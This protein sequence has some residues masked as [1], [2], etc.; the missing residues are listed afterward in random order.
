MNLREFARAV[1]NRW[2]IASMCVVAGIVVGCTFYIVRPPQYT[3]T[4]Q[5]YVSSQGDA[6]AQSAYQGAQL[7]QQRV[8]SYVELISSVRTAEEVSRSIQGQDPAELASK[9][10]ATSV[11]D[12]VLISVS[13][14][15]E[16]SEG[17][18]TLVNAVG[19][20]FPRIVSEVERTADGRS[21]VQVRPV[22]SADPPIDPSSAG[23][24]TTLLLGFVL[25]VCA[26]VA[27][28]LIRERTDRTIRTLASLREHARAPALGDV[29]SDRAV[30][31]SSTGYVALAPDSRRAEAVRKVR[32]NLTFVSVDKPPRVLCVTSPHAGDGKTTCTI[33]LAIAISWANRSVIVVDADL[34]R[35]TLAPRLALEPRVGLSQLL[36][37]RLDLNAAVQQTGI[38][39]AS[40][41]ASG[42]IP[43]NPSELLGSER[44]SDLLGEL[45]KRYDYVL[46]D[47]PPINEVVDAAV[48]GGLADGVILCAK[49]GKSTIDSVESAAQ[50]MRATGCHVVGSI[51]TMSQVESQQSYSSYGAYAARSTTATGS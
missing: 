21:L 1:R 51:L 13:A 33:D 37:G 40:A 7:S 31:A 11:P 18:A 43:P 49:S 9:I 27:A 26:A 23:L 28:V 32:T 10:V 35:P 16:S 24:G 36:S 45:A 50:R 15:D 30:V 20:V 25:G 19:D 29:P 34:R 4:L 41:L 6:S 5:M 47:T 39:R 17:A 44:M 3:A 8:A 12:S 22:D 14:T 48:V 42:P 46:V 38:T 2:L